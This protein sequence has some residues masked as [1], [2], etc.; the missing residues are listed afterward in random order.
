MEIKVYEMNGLIKGKEVKN[1]SGEVV[2][3]TIKPKKMAVI[4]NKDKTKYA[5]VDWEAI[6][7]VLTSLEDVV[8]LDVHKQDEEVTKEDGSKITHVFPFPLGTC[9]AK[10]SEIL[11]L[12]FEVFENDKDFFKDWDYNTR[13]RSNYNS[14]MDLL[15]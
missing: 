8:V 1:A 15:S 2:E 11:E 4:P 10:L 9:E 12:P 7:E 13:K 14:L 6:G 5:F 3:A